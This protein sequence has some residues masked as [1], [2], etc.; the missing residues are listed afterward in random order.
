LSVK[1]KIWITVFVLKLK[2]K[3]YQAAYEVLSDPKKRELYDK[4]GMEGVE[5]GGASGGHGM[6]LWINYFFKIKQKDVNIF[7]NFLD[8]FDILRGG[9]GR[10]QQRGA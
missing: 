2:F 6:I 5:N 7:W 9:G 4:F 8:I 1:I 10:Q 3:E